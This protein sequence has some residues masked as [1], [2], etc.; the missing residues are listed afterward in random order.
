M[1]KLSDVWLQVAPMLKNTLGK[2]S[3]VCVVDLWLRICAVLID[4][5]PA[6]LMDGLENAREALLLLR[7]ID[8]KTDD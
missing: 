5:E 8:Q 4:I 3:K 2:L 7:Q 6:A 1:V